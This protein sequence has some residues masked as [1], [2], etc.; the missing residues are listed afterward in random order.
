MMAIQSPFALTAIEAAA[1]IREREISCL[2]Y[3][4][5]LLARIE[6]AAALGAFVAIDRKAICREAAAV[7]RNL[8]EGRLEPL[9]PN[10]PPPAQNWPA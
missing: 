6:G 2:S 3:V 4:E 10:T 1:A 9:L 5:G 7:D 8:A